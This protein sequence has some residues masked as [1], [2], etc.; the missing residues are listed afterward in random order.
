[1][2]VCLAGREVVR[3]LRERYTRKDET[4]RTKHIERRSGTIVRRR[5]RTVPA[6]RF[7][8]DAIGCVLV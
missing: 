3:H 1:M 4:N 6:M 2:D 7:E 5:P 8:N